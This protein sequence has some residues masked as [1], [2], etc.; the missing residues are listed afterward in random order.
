MTQKKNCCTI[1][2][3]LIQNQRNEN[4]DNDIRIEDTA[5]TR[6][7]MWSPQLPTNY[8][9]HSSCAQMFE[10]WCTAMCESMAHLLFKPVFVICRFGSFV[11]SV[12]K[13]Y[14]NN[15]IE[16]T[17]AS[18]FCTRACIELY[19]YTHSALYPTN[20][21]KSTY[22]GSPVYMPVRSVRSLCMCVR[23]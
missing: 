13:R 17:N 19:I 11:F 5:H 23:T 2:F 10:V 3:F 15:Y 1:F 20:V 14:T 9:T 8:W 22:I 21:Y 18:L 7:T 16:A 6:F 4:I 12:Y